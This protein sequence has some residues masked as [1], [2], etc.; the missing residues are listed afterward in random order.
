MS[1]TTLTFSI[2]SQSRKLV[3]AT[4]EAPEA[5]CNNV[6]SRVFSMAST[7]VLQSDMY[8][9]YLRDDPRGRAVQLQLH[10]QRVDRE[11]LAC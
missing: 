5:H 4:R 7:E 1:L 6:K 9:S 10:R 8:L 2:K 3:V 11:F